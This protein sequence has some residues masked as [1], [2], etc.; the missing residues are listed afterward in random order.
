MSC[1]FAHWDGVYVLGSL[2][3]SERAAYERHLSGCAEC[4]RAVRE[5]AGLPGLMARVPLEALEPRGEREPVPETLLPAVVSEVRRSQRRR[6]SAMAA[7]V[8]AAAAIVVVGVTGVV[9]AT[10]DDDEGP[11]STQPAPSVS[12]APAEQMDS[13]GTGWVTGWISLTEQAW[14]T[15]IDLT[16]TYRGAG[17]DGWATYA[18]IVRTTDGSVE[19]VGTWRAEPGRE[20]HVTLATSALPEEIESVLVRTAQGASVMRL[21]K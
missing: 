6:R 10:L 21:A 13:L 5:L 4:S 2:A 9:V 7:V 11:P 16:C 8:A 18:M 19:Q 12:T 15:R 14:G 3:A 1:E 20:V 17:Y